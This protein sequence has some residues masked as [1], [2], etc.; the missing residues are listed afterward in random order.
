MLLTWCVRRCKRN[1]IP[2][3]IPFLRRSHPLSCGAVVS[4]KSPVLATHC[5]PVVQRRPVWETKF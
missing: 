3:A 4:G 2:C 5:L 1:E